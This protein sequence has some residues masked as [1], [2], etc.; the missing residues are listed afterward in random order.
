MAAHHDADARGV[1]KPP[2]RRCVPTSQGDAGAREAARAVD[3]STTRYDAAYRALRRELLTS[4]AVAEQLR[5]QVLSCQA[6]WP[7]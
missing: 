1:P 4:S 2:Q 6:Q 5:L 3:E 7:R